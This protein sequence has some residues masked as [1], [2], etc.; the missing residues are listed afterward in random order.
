MQP[1]ERIIAL[2]VAC[3][4]FM[5]SMDQTVL[6]TALATIAADFGTD[7]VRLHLAM[8]CYL[9]SLAVFMPVS[10]W[11]ADRFGARNVFCAAVAI[12]TLA[13]I[14][15]AFAP[16]LGAL[17]LGRIVQGAG[18]AMM[19]P[20]ARLVLLRSVPK[21]QL[22]NAMAWVSI[23]AL[24]G[25]LVGPPVGGLIVTY[26]SWP[27]VFWINVP[28]GILGIALATIFMPDIREA[29]R[30][31]FDFRGF[32]F[33]A[34]GVSGV[35]LGF[36]TVGDAVMPLW[37]NGLMALVGVAGLVLYLAHARRRI[38]PILDLSLLRIRT[39]SA[40]VLG[41]AL[42]RVGIG[43]LPFLLPL[44]LQ[45]GF[46]F[47]PLASGL[48]TLAAAI[49]AM[50]MKFLAAPLIRRFGF[51]SVLLWN[52]VLSGASIAACA[53]FSAATP[54][55]AIFIVLLVG[56]FFRS[57]EFTALNAVSYADVPQPRMS[58]ATAFASMVQQIAL[59]VGIGLAAM[60]LY[61]VRDPVA[62]VAPSDFLIA[63]ALIGALVVGS[64]VN[65]AR[66]PPDAGD[67]M[68]NRAAAPRSAS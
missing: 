58:D 9:L 41:G 57:L 38:R 37:M 62:G 30:R 33:V 15:C 18:G 42:F 19:V 59:S 49:G 63:L 20:V 28:I 65:F 1:R 53:L 35:V 7:P 68:A 11:I 61:L 16:N 21:A 5:Q 44:M 24:V 10:G 56:G 2:I 50:T 8:T 64:A 60:I 55:W 34:L 12:F 46:G 3:A 27:W 29:E 67:E 23:P 54:I 14:A 48:T 32:L 4:M 31:A 25:P 45:A 13:S 39:F 52:A 51:R 26:L 22:I 43:A 40:G 47:T 36:E 6:G 66:L 17:V